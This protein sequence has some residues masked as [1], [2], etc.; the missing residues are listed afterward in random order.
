M[1]RADELLEHPLADR[2]PSFTFIMSRDPEST[3]LTA[4]NID[5]NNMDKST[6]CTALS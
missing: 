1:E 5:W 4:M 6:G 3:L 2:A